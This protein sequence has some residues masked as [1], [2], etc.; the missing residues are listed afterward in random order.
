[1]AEK[2]QLNY[3]PAAM[4]EE[5]ARMVSEL[6]IDALQYVW[7]PILYAYNWVDE[8]DEEAMVNDDNICRW[9]L[10]ISAA[11]ETQKHVE[12]VCEYSSWLQN[13]NRKKKARS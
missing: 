9:N 11:I 5:L 1:M 7:R 8:H 2:L 3:N 13:F 6:S 4:R 12:D 10:I